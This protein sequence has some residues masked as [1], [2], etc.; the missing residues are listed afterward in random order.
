MSAPILVA[1]DLGAAA[2]EAL[3]QADQ[4]ARL[5]RAPLVV[6][7]VAPR[8]LGVEPLMPHL[9]SR[10]AMAQAEMEAGVDERVRERTA[11][12]TGR[13]PRDFEVAVVEGDVVAEIVRQAEQRRA[14]LVAV[15]GHVHHGRPL[16][17]GDSADR[18]LRHAHCSVLVARPH[19]PTRRVVVGIDGS[20]LS[21]T[22]LALAAAWARR[23][24]AQLTLLDSIEPRMKPILS[25]AN[26]GA[27]DGFVERE[28]TDARA[29]SDRLLREALAR[30]DADGERRISE[31]EP[32]RAILDAATALDADLIAVGAT[33]T[34]ALARVTLG[35]VGEKVARHASCSVLV[36]RA[37]S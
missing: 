35:R 17:L 1:T 31:A 10:Q 5:Q 26:F 9:L 15:G 28:Y 19:P 24:E 11:A 7:H 23:A 20:P 32:A 25:M 4:W 14:A 34:T 2:D 8:L 30:V 3:R 27:D 36:A 12:I 33:G 21:L 18:V 29:E 37:G 22:A 6:C 13:D 16:L